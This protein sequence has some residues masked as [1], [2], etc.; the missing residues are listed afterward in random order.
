MGPSTKDNWFNIHVCC[1]LLGMAL[2]VAG[3]T[4]AFVKLN[5]SE[6]VRGPHNYRILHSFNLRILSSLL[7]FL[8]NF[9]MQS[10][11]TVLAHKWVGVVVTAL[12]SI[13]LVIGFMRPHPGSEWRPLWNV[14]HHY[15]GRL[16]IIL[17]WVAVL[18]GGWIVY[19]KGYMG[20]QVKTHDVT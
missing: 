13:Q 2:F 17:A 18:I 6:Q 5:V 20:S 16:A 3:V 10:D 15:T 4:L 14:A 1:Q 9:S 7:A 11:G 8:L 12:G 19:A